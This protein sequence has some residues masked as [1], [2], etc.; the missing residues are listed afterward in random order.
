M[1][2]SQVISDI[3]LITL[4]D[5]LLEQGKES[6]TIKYES[7]E[8]YDV[9]AKLSG[10]NNMAEVLETFAQKIIRNLMVSHVDDEDKERRIVD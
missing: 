5:S 4:A 6:E 2:K 7:K 1:Y 10:H 9:L 3:S 8:T